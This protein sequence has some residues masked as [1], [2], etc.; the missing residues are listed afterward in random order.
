MDQC[1]VLGHQRQDLV[2][3]QMSTATPAAPATSAAVAPAQ[4]QEPAPQPVQS[5]PPVQGGPPRHGRKPGSKNF[6]DAEVIHLL[7]LPQRDPES[8]P[9]ALTPQT[10]S[11]P[12]PVRYIATTFGLCTALP[13]SG[14]HI[15]DV[16]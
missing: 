8:P 5:Q 7:D 13:R 2:I 15:F 6:S 4:L 1:C 12:A 9:P 16:T 10:T 3:E 11:G 14:Q